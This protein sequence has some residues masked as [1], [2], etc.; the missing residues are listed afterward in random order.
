[1]STNIK[2]RNFLKNSLFVAGG[3]VLAPNIISCSSDN[4][5]FAIQIPPNLTENNFNQGVASFD[6]TNNQVII[7]TRYESSAASVQLVWQLATDSNFTEVIREG[8]IT[9]DAS[10]DYTIAIEVK[11]L[12]AGLKLY[13]RFVQ[14]TNEDVSPIGET[15]T[16]AENIAEA[17]LAVASC[18]NYAYG[19]FNV[20]QAIANSDADVVVHLGDYIYE[21]GPDTYGSFRTPVPAGEI[22]SMDDYRARYRQYRSDDQLKELHRRKPLICVWDDHEITN[23]A[24][25]DGAENHQD[26]EGDYGV[27]KQVALQVYSEY[28]PNTTNI[29]DN[30]IIYRK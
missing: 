4:E 18:A 17:K 1:M 9:T 30:A 23:D 12:E 16:F 28:L 8:E 19:Y 6:P 14:I 22:I 25:V 3:I 26:N 7:W 24:Y 10:R 27:R 5:D 21:Y 29:A 13:Y 2:R 11:D 20:Y 15:L